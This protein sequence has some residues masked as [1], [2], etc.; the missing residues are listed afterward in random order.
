MTVQVEFYLNCDEADLMGD[1]VKK[2]NQLIEDGTLAEVFD[3]AGGGS[4]GQRHLD[5]G[6]RV[7][8]HINRSP[9]PSWDGSLQGLDDD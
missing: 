7:Q 9:N 2:I 8:L 5:N 6:E 3:S 1:C 4:S